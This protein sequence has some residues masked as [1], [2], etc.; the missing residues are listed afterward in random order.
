LRKGKAAEGASDRKYA[1]NDGFRNMIVVD[2][3]EKYIY[4]NELGPEIER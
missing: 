4:G 1:Y 2:N 3:Y